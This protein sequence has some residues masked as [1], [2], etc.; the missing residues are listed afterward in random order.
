MAAGDFNIIN[1]N[2]AFSFNIIP[3]YVVSVI[4]DKLYPLFKI[5][6][7]IIFRIGLIPVYL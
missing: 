6:I 1:K 5:Q 7:A 4:S 3:V 2:A